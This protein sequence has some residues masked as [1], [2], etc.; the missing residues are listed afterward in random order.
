[1][2]IH[3]L[4]DVCTLNVLWRMVAGSGF[5]QDDEKVLKLLELVHNA[6]HLQDM[7]GGLLNQ[8]PFLQWIA[9]EFSGFNKLQ[10]TV[11]QIIDFMKVFFPKSW[12]MQN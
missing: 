11:K 6:F 1:M 4:V 2:E 10:S 9:P 12:S 5:K 3:Q 7:S 8:M